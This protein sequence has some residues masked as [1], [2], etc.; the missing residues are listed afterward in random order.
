MQRRIGGNGHRTIAMIR[1]M[2]AALPRII[3]SC[4][5]EE[6]DAAEDEWSMPGG[7][8]RHQDCARREQ[9][10][11]IGHDEPMVA[12]F[13]LARWTDQES[14]LTQTGVPIGTRQY[15]SPEQ[16]LGKKGEFRPWQP[17]ALQ[18]AFV[19]GRYA[20]WHCAGA[21]KTLTGIGFLL[22]CYEMWM[23]RTLAYHRAGKPFLLFTTTVGPTFQMAEAFSN[24]TTLKS[25]V[26][27]AKSHRR[28]KDLSLEDYLAECEARQQPPVI[29]LGRENMPDV[30]YEGGDLLP[31]LRGYKPCGVVLDEIHR[32]KSHKMA[33]YNK[34]KKG[35]DSAENQAAALFDLLNKTW[36]DIPYRLALSASPI[37]NN[38]DDLWAQFHQL[39]PWS[40]GS[41]YDYCI[42]YAAGT[43]G[44][45]G[46]NARGESNQEEFASRVV[47]LRH[48]VTKEEVMPFLPPVET[49]VVRIPLEAQGKGETSWKA[50]VKGL[51][52][53]KDLQGMAVFATQVAA[54]RKRPW[55]VQQV[56]DELRL[57]RKVLVFTGFRADVVRIY[58]AVLERLGVPLR[59]EEEGEKKDYKSEAWLKKQVGSYAHA[60]V[61]AYAHFGSARAP[62]ETRAMCKEY[63]DQEGCAFLVGT[64]ESIGESYNL[65]NTDVL[66]F[67]QTPPDMIR[68]TQQLGRVETRLSR[69]RK[70]TIYFPLAEET[71]DIRLAEI[72]QPKA[73]L[74]GRMMGDVGATSLMTAM[75]GS[76]AELRAEVDKYLQACV[77][78]GTFIDPESLE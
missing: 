39:D 44:E 23:Q 22:K 70:V 10:P 68:L 47:Y 56:V 11:E 57:G 26:Y 63:N 6:Y 15:M 72:L 30:V 49:I 65:E 48:V 31:A 27:K 25:W 14:D 7:D 38:V 41:W 69:K 9:R 33:E 55:V 34:E 37:G 24:F 8:L 29:I 60:K 51:A 36:G 13:G 71:Y 32:F 35:F 17:A 19:Y 45:Y 2:P 62:E 59:E 75:R 18:Q 46:F 3:T 21:G 76:D 58:R 54:E 74:V 78:A 20:A 12:D 61:K 66:I 64:G 4:S 5:D 42:R 73:G 77:E 67:A 43:K 40:F 16:T 1:H 28:K 52:K 50:E 53:N